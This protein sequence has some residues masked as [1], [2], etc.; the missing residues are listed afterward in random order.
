MTASDYGSKGWVGGIDTWATHHLRRLARTSQ[1]G[2]RAS[3]SGSTRSRPGGPG[4]RRPATTDPYRRR[5]PEHLC[6]VAVQAET[7]AAA[8]SND[9][10]IRFA[11]AKSAPEPVRRAAVELVLDL[12][13]IA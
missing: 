12:A 8:V 9:W 4:D 6:G 1:L 7:L 3:S 2:A 5:D 11:E 10:S 13:T